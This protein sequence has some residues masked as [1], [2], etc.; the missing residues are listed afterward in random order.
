[1]NEYINELLKNGFIQKSTPRYDVIK[2]RG[3]YFRLLKHNEQYCK[4]TARSWAY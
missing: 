4:V 3:Q 2:Y 1:M